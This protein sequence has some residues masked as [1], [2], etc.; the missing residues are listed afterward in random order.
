MAEGSAHG[1]QQPQNMPM[2]QVDYYIR[3]KS[4]FYKALQASGWVLPKYTSSIVTMEFLLEV[5]S[6]QIY[7]PREA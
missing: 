4:H 2:S 6:G 5:R 1:S 7:C 3:N